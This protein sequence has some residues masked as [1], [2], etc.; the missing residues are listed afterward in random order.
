MVMKEEDVFFKV[1]NEDEQAELH[2]SVLDNGELLVHV[3]PEHYSTAS[4]ALTPS[5][6]IELANYILNRIK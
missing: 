2:V 3:L 1:I 5:E 6:S 4:I